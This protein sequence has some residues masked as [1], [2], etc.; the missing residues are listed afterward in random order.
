MIEEPKPRKDGRC[1][2]CKKPITTVT[3]YGASDAFHS[4]RCAREYFG[5]SLEID[6]EQHRSALAQRIQEEKVA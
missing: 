1:L 2:V 5:T 6:Q 4:A 3:T